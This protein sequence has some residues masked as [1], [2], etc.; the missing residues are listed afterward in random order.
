MALSSVVVTGT[1]AN[2]PS[3]PMKYPFRDD[4]VLHESRALR[5]FGRATFAFTLPN[6][7]TAFRIYAVAI[8]PELSAG[9]GDTSIVSTRDLVVR[10]ALPRIV[11]AGDELFAGAVLTKEGSGRVPVSLSVTATNALVLDNSTLRDTLDGAA[12]T[13]VALPT[14]R[15]GRGRCDI[16]LSRYDSLRVRQL[17]TPSKPSLP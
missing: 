12:L 15:H 7:I 17:T 4:S 13:R 8:G 2:T 10:P 11:R 3:A 9:S 6:N 5:W 1:G 14:T 16:R